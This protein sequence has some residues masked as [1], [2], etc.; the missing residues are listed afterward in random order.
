MPTFHVQ[1]G[2]PLTITSHRFPGTIRFT[3]GSYVTDD[4][5]LAAYLRRRVDVAEG[6]PAP[7]RDQMLRADLDEE[8]T[9]LGLDP[10]DYATKADITEAIADAGD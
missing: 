5:V 7:P 3:D 9:A 1:P 4:P 10:S 8:A 6:E 2:G